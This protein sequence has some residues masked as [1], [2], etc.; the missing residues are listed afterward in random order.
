MANN[1][2]APFGQER[3]AQEHRARAEWEREQASRLRAEARGRPSSELPVGH[4]HVAQAHEDTARAYERR[5]KELDEAM[6]ATARRGEARGKSRAELVSVARAAAAS[7]FA[8]RKVAPSEAAIKKA[9]S[10][11]FDAI[12]RAD[13]LAGTSDHPV[14]AYSHGIAELAAEG[15]EEARQR[16]EMARESTRKLGRRSHATVAT[17]DY[18]YV[19]YPEPSHRNAE[20]AVKIPR[21]QGRGPYDLRD[22]KAAAKQ[23]GSPAAI[24]SV[25]KGRFVGYIHGNG[26]FVPFR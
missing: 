20:R 24:Y 11:A 23:M 26:R 6:V 18:E 5:A 13:R 15:T 1:P 7:V 9:R 17:R 14:A 16:W 22:A 8:P 3:T 4:E 21:R 10:K 19:V 25:S 12:R 2:S